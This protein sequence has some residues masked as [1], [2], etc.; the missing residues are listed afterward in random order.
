MGIVI[1]ALLELVVLFFMKSNVESAKTVLFCIV[2]AV[3]GSIAT[4]SDLPEEAGNEKMPVVQLA[5]A[6]LLLVAEAY[7]AGMMLL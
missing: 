4:L 3:G 1:T 5:T 7:A 6:A 2:M